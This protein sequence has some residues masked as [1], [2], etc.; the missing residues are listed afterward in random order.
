MPVGFCAV[1][2][3]MAGAWGSLPSLVFMKALFL[4]EGMKV[5]SMVEHVGLDE[6]HKATSIRSM[7]TEKMI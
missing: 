1:E 2:A 7:N 3:G 4:A 6:S 5:E